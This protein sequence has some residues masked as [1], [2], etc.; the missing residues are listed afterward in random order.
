MT[1]LKIPKLVSYLTVFFGLDFCRI[2]PFL[3]VTP[4]TNRVSVARLGPRRLGCHS[5]IHASFTWP[6]RGKA[7][8][9]W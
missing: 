7:L 1:T 5:A 3:R 2:V 8:I 4:V 9:V 6:R